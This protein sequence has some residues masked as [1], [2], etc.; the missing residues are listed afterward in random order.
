MGT[1]VP[2]EHMFTLILYLSALNTGVISE[3]HLKQTPLHKH[4]ALTAVM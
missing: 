4:E 2:Y 3:A 1:C